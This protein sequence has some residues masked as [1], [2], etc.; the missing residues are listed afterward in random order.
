CQTGGARLIARV[1]GRAAQEIGSKLTITAP[2]D[3]LHWFGG[4]GKRIEP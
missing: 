3:K 4:D 1:A 2:T